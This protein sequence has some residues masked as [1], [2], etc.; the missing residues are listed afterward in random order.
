MRLFS[1]T[2]GNRWH[3]KPS[4]RI[5]I[6]AIGVGLSLIGKNAQKKVW[7]TLGIQIFS[8][9]LDLFGVL[10]L[11]LIGTIAVT[12]IQS[13]G[14]SDKVSDVIKLLQLENTSLQRQVAYLALAATLML[15]CRTF[16]SVFLTRR[17]LFFLAHQASG[18]STTLFQRLMLGPLSTI[19]LR[20]SQLNLYALTDGVVVLTLGVLG[21]AITLLA[22]LSLLVILGAGLFFVDPLIALATIVIFGFTAAVL[23]RLLSKRA[24]S[25]GEKN[26][27]YSVQSAEITIGALKAFREIWVRRTSGAYVQKFNIARS[28]ISDSLAESQFM[29]NIS[30]YVIESILLVMT[31]LYCGLQFSLRDASDAIATLTVFLAS[32]SR[33]AP[34]V[35]R[36]QQGLIQVNSNSVAAGPTVELLNDLSESANVSLYKNYSNSAQSNKLLVPTIKFTKVSFTHNQGVPEYK[37]TSLE[38]S[39]GKKIM[40]TGPSGGGKTTFVDLILGLHIPLTGEVTIG[41]LAPI[42]AINA[43][44]GNIA[45]VPQ[46]VSIIHATLRDNLLL[47]IPCEE[48]S[49]DNLIRLLNAMELGEF[50]AGLESGL[51]TILNEDGSNISGGQKQRLGIARALVTCPSLLILDEATSAL[52]DATEDLILD[53]L[54]SELNESTVILITHKKSLKKYFDDYLL[55]EKMQI[56]H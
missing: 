46:N 47:G 43:Y 14:P 36:I 53:R 44:P 3:L 27:K 16:I 39:A 20:N 48:S 18:I 1:K 51:D 40:V 56:T 9:L 31:L 22:D 52:D 10:L 4:N 13:R 34:A 55:I 5:I 15:L 29:P 19:Q 8:G 24:M 41:G 33:I 37:N 28:H 23:N 7:I 17:T 35:M 32:A 2:L 49:D 45:Y 42:E 12:G 21:T 11:G 6:Q 38:I 54:F 30:K 50:F 25:I 26:Q